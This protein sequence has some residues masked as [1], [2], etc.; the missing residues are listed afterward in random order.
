MKKNLSII[1][2]HFSSSKLLEKLLATIPQDKD[3]IEII[4]IDDKS[5]ET[6]LRYIEN[7]Q[8]KYSFKLFYNETEKKGAG[9]AR[10]IGL[11]QASGKWILFADSDDYFIDNFY[12]II[13]P[14]FCIESDVVFFKTTSIYLDT[15]EKSD[16]HINVNNILDKYLKS[17]GEESELYVRYGLKVPWGKIIKKDLIFK[18]SITFD[19]ILVSND[20]M[21]STKVGFNMDKFRVIDQVLYVVTKNKGSLTTNMDESVFDTRLDT[22]LRHISFLKENLSQEEIKLFNISRYGRNYL[23]TSIKYG[24][25]IFLKTLYILYKNGIGFFHYKLLNPFHII[26]RS[27]RV[28]K[29]F[30]KNSKYT[31]NKKTGL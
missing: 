30:K 21:F 16:R 24:P 8:K 19:E 12:D 11:V 10:N 15:D 20:V 6:H 22:I 29:K 25:L 9:V 13:S 5:E 7:L 3:D 1:I 2:P 26:S 14:Y 28:F 23:L 27:I 4:V 17:L 18:H 31:I